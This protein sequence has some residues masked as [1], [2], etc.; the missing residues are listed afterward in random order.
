LC[1]ITQTDDPVRRKYDMRQ[2]SIVVAGAMLVVAVMLGARPA[3]A[4]TMAECSAKYQAAKAANALKG[5]SWN[6]FRKGQCADED[7]D[8]KAAAAAAPDEPAA[9]PAAGMPK[10]SVSKAAFPRAVDAK[11]KDETPGRARL[12]TCADQWNAN[13]AKDVN[14]NGGLRWI[15][16]GG[17]YWSECNKRLKAAAG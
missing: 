1:P 9:K 15:Q 5:Q 4:L 6:Q 12:H 13:K 10:P 17:G 7:V 3:A 11:Y 8:E 16:K 14:L 2:S